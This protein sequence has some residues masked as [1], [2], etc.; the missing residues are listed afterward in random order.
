MCTGGYTI[1]LTR[2]V[3]F[4]LQNSVA[5]S[6]HFNTSHKVLLSEP[7]KLVDGFELTFHFVTNYVIKLFFAPSTCRRGITEINDEHDD[8]FNQQAECE[9]TR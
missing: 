7:Q 9:C 4:Q 5:M 2:T 3:L 8:R 1:I 6:T